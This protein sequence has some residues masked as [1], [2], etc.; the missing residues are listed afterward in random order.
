MIDYI[1]GGSL[2]SAWLQ[3]VAKVSYV[4]GANAALTQKGLQQNHI[5]TS[6]HLHMQ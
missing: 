6:E 4:G 5:Y 2:N 3:Y 1:C